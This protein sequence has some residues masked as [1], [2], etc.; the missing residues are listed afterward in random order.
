MEFEWDE[1]KARANASKHRVTFKEA[2]EVFRDRLSDTA[3]DP[4]HS[5]EESRFVILGM[6]SANR[7]LYISFT[8][9]DDII[10]II[11][12]REATQKERKLYEDQP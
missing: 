11:S 2:E 10:R 4:D 5:D 6:T 1:T 12:A 3:D 9:R 7:L 8:E